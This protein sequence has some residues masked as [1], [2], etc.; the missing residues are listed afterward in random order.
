ME[1]IIETFHIDWKII[2]A[3]GINFAIVF[4]VLYVFALK[5]LNKLMNERSETIGK[6]LKDAKENAAILSETT[7]KYEEAIAKSKLEANLIFQTA[8]KEAEGKRVEMLEEAKSQVAALIENG[9]KTL[10]AE[11]VKMVG[12]A[13]KEIVTLAML[14]TEKLTGSKDFDQKAIKDLENL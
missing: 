4:A 5:P 12:E 1:S 13:R 9:K 6:G 11:K 3:Q 10:E 14:A 7:S 2:I 8:K